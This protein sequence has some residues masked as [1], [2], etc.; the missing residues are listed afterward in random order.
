MA[1]CHSGT[2]TEG[3]SYPP[4]QVDVKATSERELPSAPDVTTHALLPSQSPAPRIW[5][6]HEEMF[7]ILPSTVNTVREAASRVRQIQNI[8]VS[9]PTDNSF[10]KILTQ[11]DHQIQGTSIADPKQVRLTDRERRGITSTPKKPEIHG[12][13]DPEDISQ[14]P[15][16]EDMQVGRQHHMSYQEGL[17]NSL[18]LAATEFCK[19]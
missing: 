3:N 2:N 4:V 14:I 12:P 16:G 13:Q 7:H 19:I 8:V 5:V 17:K 9:N 18:Q 10:E 6:L 1:Y 15:R 11:A